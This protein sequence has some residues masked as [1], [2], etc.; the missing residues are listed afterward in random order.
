MFPPIIFT[1]VA[2]MATGSIGG[3]LVELAASVAGAHGNVFALLEPMIWS[4]LLAAPLLLLIGLTDACLLDR[5]SRRPE[6][7]QRQRPVDDF[8]HSHERRGK[9]VILSRL[10]PNRMNDDPKN[11]RA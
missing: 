8:G 10:N 2:A 4:T 11:P 1:F 3:L 9:E 6:L 7:R 5:L